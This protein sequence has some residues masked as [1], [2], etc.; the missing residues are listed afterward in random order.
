MNRAFL[1][2]LYKY[3]KPYRLFLLLSVMMAFISALITLYIPLLTGKAVDCVLGPGKVD[4]AGTFGIMARIALAAVISALSQYLMNISNN[5]MAGRVVRDMRDAAFSKIERLPLKY[6]DNHPYGDL[7]SRVISD[8]DQFSDGLLMGFSQFFTGLVTIFGTLFFMLRLDFKLGLLVV[9]L[10][11]LSFFVARF[12]S[13]RTYRYSRRQ[14]EIRGK[15]TAFVNEMINGARVTKAFNREERVL[16]DFSGINEEFREASLKATFF[17]SLTNPSTRFVN[18]V[19]YAAI[20]IVGA[21][22]V[23]KG[24]LT[25]GGLTSFLS[26]AREYTRPFNEISGVVTELQNAF[27]C[28]ERLMDLI[29]EKP[30]KPDREDAVTLINPE[31]KIDIENLSFSYSD[32]KK[33]IED[34]NLSVNPGQHIAIAGPTGCGKTTLINLLMRFYDIK[35]GSIRVDGVDTLMVTRKSLRDSFGM[36]LQDTW[37]KSGTIRENLIMGDTSV[38]DEEMI[39]A[40][41]ACHAHS[42]IRKLPKGYDTYISED[43]GTLSAGQKQLLCITRAML[44]KPSMLI[45]DEATSSIDTRTEIKIQE[46]FHRI[47]DGKTGFIVAHRLS[48]IR[49]ADLI[50]VMKDG[51]II[52]Q[53]SHEELLAHKG[54]YNELYESQ[55]AGNA[56]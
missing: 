48:T 47:M 27:A 41:K 25:V 26:Y 52:E 12:I 35:Y 23:M 30:E 45:L 21:N 13:S 54:F 29:E 18:N 2:K 17:S 8:A 55:F 38:S 51:N 15:E 42:F 16:Q 32:D 24:L 44:S 33:L 3:L 14:A 49:E 11:P 46:A 4:F 7:L 20:A 10:T 50:L 34:F 9:V 53:G 5:A 43:G 22:S 28:A 37:L 19:I 36:V 6:L 1:K 31:G 40:A 56:T 39:A